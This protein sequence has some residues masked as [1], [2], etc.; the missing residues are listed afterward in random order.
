MQEVTCPSCVAACEYK[1]SLRRGDV[2]ECPV[3]DESYTQ[4][5]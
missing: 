3:C 2:Y 1:C 5:A 4:F